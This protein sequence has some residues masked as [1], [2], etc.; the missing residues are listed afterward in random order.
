MSFSSNYA[1]TDW[2]YICLIILLP[3]KE[4][5]LYSK[6]NITIWLRDD[7]RGTSRREVSVGI[8]HIEPREQW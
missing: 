6:A 5:V 1:A 7:A 3:Q 4:T 2:D 8:L